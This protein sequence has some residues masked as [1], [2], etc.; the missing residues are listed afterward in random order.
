M[1]NKC[2][3]CESV[4]NELLKIDLI[5]SFK[6]FEARFICKQ[7]ENNFIKIKGNKCLFCYKKGEFEAN[8]CLECIQ[9]EQK[10]H[11]K[12]RNDALYEYNDAMHDFFQKYK[13]N[14][15]FRLRKIFQ[16]EMIEKLKNTSE[17]IVPIPI[18]KSTLK[19]RGFNQVIGLIEGVDYFEC[20]E[21]LK[22]KQKQSKKNRQER[23][24]TKQPFSL[25]KENLKNITGKKVILL[26]DI[27]TTGATLRH[28]AK[29][30]LDAGVKEIRSVTLAR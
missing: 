19:D 15:N 9:W 24:K 25:V 3:V 21:V 12:L 8:T 18:S 14:G 6:K 10:Y 4:I 2:L 16:K 23:L 1:K 28:A 22:Q 27:Y 11:F 30:L 13:F 26:D 17:V 20:L 29:I 5:F 7:C